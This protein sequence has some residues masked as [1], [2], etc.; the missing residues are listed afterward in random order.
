MNDGAS[1]HDVIIDDIQIEGYQAPLFVRHGCR[2]RSADKPPGSFSNLI[3]R[4]ITIE[5][6]GMLGSSI[7]GHPEN[8]LQEIHL[9]KIEVTLQTINTPALAKFAHGR[10]TLEEPLPYP[11]GKMFG[12]LPA[13]ALYVRH[14]DPIGPV[15]FFNHRGDERPGVV[16]EP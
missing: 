9:E 8:P 7:H 10:A 1:L 16:I 13:A 3:L 14:A 11:D 2:G 6:D 5:T 15:V 12:P 4:N